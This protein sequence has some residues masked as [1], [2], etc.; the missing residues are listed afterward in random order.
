[1]ATTVIMQTYSCE[2][3]DDGSHMLRSDYSIDCDSHKHQLFEVYSGIMTA[4]YPVVSP[5]HCSGSS[6]PSIH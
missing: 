6:H 1:M 5:R 4:I 3:F 2:M